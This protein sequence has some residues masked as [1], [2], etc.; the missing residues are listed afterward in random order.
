MEYQF[1]FF[2][3]WVS[4]CFD[5]CPSEEFAVNYTSTRYDYFACS[6]CCH[7]SNIHLR[8]ILFTDSIIIGVLQFIFL[9]AC[10]YAPQPTP[11]PGPGSRT[12][13]F[14][15]FCTGHNW[16]KFWYIK[17]LFIYAL[18]SSIFIYYSLKLSIEYF[19]CQLKPFTG[20]IN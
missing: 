3:C 2:N 4:K 19:I 5:L 9:K 7:E 13:P 16:S 17:L 12:L 11:P 15:L 1:Y 10:H 20:C 6:N 14:A 18:F 8:L